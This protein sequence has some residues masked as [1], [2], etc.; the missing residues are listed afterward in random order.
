[1]SSPTL[2]SRVF[3]MWCGRAENGPKSERSTHERSLL[4]ECKSCPFVGLKEPTGRE[5]QAQYRQL[6]M[7]DGACV[8]V[9][10][11]DQP[12]IV[13]VIWDDMT[14][15]DFRV[16]VLVRRWKVWKEIP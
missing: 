15:L 13:W 12:A 6:G 11:K 8:P 9:G 5:L 1:M 4:D 7:L 3:A 14:I 2:F 10:V 16:R